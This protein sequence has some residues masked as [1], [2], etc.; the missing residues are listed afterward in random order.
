[1]GIGRFLGFV[2]M[3]GLI[4]AAVMFGAPI[5]VFIDVP[6]AI[7]VLG[8][9]TCGAFMSFPAGRLVAAFFG[10][11]GG[12]EEA[13][14]RAHVLHRV[15][16]LAVAS[17]LVGTIIGLVQMLQGLDDPTAIGP[18]MAVA[19]LTLFY[20]VVLGE[21]VLR[22]LASGAADASSGAKA[23]PGRRGAVSIY[24]PIASLFILMFCFFVM[25]LAMGNPG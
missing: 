13:A 8:V 5:T 3:M 18:A 9:T 6:S 10:S 19:L 7:L 11:G 20:G 2:A 24:V 22:S 16:D 25:L 23:A 17:G 1:M 12:A 4:A 21:L 14:Q 15:A